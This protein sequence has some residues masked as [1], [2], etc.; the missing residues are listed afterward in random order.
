MSRC[1]CEHGQLAHV[2]GN[3]ACHGIY[4]PLDGSAHGWAPCECRAYVEAPAP[5]PP[6]LERVRRHSEVQR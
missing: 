3:G 4:Q 5:L 1:I 2:G 6:S